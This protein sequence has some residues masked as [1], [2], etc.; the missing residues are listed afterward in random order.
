MVEVADGNVAAV[1]EKTANG[2]AVMAMIDVEV[3]SSAGI[4]TAA[5]RASSALLGKQPIIGAQRDAVPRSQGVIFCA[6]GIIRSPLLRVGRCL[7]Q[8]LAAPF[9]MSL[10][11]AWLAVRSKIVER[12]FVGAKHL[13]RQRFLAARA[14]FY[15]G[16]IW[17]RMC[18]VCLPM[19]EQSLYT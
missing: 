17:S 18:H 2:L 8:I 15:D 4:A 7:I 14:A 1:A 6:P 19:S 3:S 13:A 11:A 12:Q 5:D 9:V 10:H 16:R